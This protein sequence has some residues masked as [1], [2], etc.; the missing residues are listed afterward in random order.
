M[1]L[2]LQGRTVAVSLQGGVEGRKS[3][4][5]TVAILCRLERANAELHNH[6]LPKADAHDHDASLATDVDQPGNPTRHLAAS[7]E[8]RLSKCQHRVRI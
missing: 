8:P 5:L 3:S 7:M 1:T 4:G 6:T 2:Q